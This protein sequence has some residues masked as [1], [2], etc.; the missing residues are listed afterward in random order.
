MP[1]LMNAIATAKGLVQQTQQELADDA[2]R[3]ECNK[4]NSEHHYP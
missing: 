2:L 3:V 1:L 4:I